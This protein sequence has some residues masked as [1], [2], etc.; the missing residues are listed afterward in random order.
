LTAQLERTALLGSPLDHEQRILARGRRLP[1]L[2]SLAAVLM[3][4][5]ALALLVLKVLPS[6]TPKVE[7]AGGGRPTRLEVEDTDPIASKS[8][9][10]LVHGK[11]GANEDVSG[12]FPP[13]TLSNPL[14]SANQAISSKGGDATG[15]AVQQPEQTV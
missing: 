3:L 2:A 11:S 12:T 5:G 1:Q 6:S 15:A 8:G 14:A 13:Q 4:A 7:Y 9:D 10:A